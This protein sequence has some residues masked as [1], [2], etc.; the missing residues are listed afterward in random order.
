VQSAFLDIEWGKF[1]YPV[2]SAAG[3]GFETPDHEHRIDRLLSLLDDIAALATRRVL[4]KQDAERWAY[5]FVRVFDNE[6]VQKY[7]TFL[8]EF[9]ARNGIKSGPHLMAWDWYTQ[10]KRTT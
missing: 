2:S 5:I 3:N 7:M 9:Y 8:R 1:Q 10:I 6:A 4:R